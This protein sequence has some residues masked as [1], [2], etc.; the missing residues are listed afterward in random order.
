MSPIAVVMNLV[1]VV[2]LLSAL[3][4]G[5]RLER[6]LKA[7]RDGQ[8]VFAGA[9]ADLDRAAQRAERGLAELRAATDEAIDLLAG[10]IEKARELA[11]RLE[12]LT[13]D[14]ARPVARASAEPPRAAAAA[15]TAPERAPIRGPIRAPRPAADL[16][17][18]RAEAAAE[19]LVLRLT[20]RQPP[21]DA[22]AARPARLEP[23]PTARSR[24]SI[25]DEL[26]E[27]APRASL[28]GRR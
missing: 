28:G 21:Q 18:D 2:L 19:D 4:F 9:V 1:L 17:P 20:E 8:A 13:A 12:T 25:D 5:V 3:G 15:R 24:A 11:G 10:R 23:R 22:P 26:F 6:R 7:L 16:P 14:A 27:S